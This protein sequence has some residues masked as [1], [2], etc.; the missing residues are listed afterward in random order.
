MRSPRTNSCLREERTKLNAA[1]L[2]PG[3]M[4]WMLPS[5]DLALLL[6]RRALS[7]QR[8]QTGSEA[9]RAL[10]TCEHP[11]LAAHRYSR[12]GPCTAHTSRSSGGVST[13][14]SAWRASIL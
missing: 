11:E 7:G 1:I 13:A 2:S 3:A 9:R 14:A 6:R 8:L 4:V 12:E 5:A 10:V